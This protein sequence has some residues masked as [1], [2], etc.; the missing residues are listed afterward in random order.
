MHES[1]WI[2]AKLFWDQGGPQ[3]AAF[4][5]IS[6]YQ[7]IKTVTDARNPQGGYCYAKLSSRRGG[8][9]FCQGNERIVV[10]LV[11]YLGKA[12]FAIGNEHYRSQQLNS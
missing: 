12:G 3:S 2:G 5:H 9:V 1:D 11:S 4:S 7:D 8:I 10:V 6:E